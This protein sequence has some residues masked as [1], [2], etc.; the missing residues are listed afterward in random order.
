M[1]THYRDP[2]NLSY[3]QVLGKLVENISVLVDDFN[4]TYKNIYLFHFYGEGFEIK[5]SD[6]W[7]TIQTKIDSVQI[8]VNLQYLRYYKRHI[9]YGTTTPFTVFTKVPITKLVAAGYVYKTIQT[10][11]D[12]IDFSVDT[13]KIRKCET[14]S[15]HIRYEFQGMFGFKKTLDDSELEF[16]T[17]IRTAY[18][19]GFDLDGKEYYVDHR[20]SDFTNANVVAHIKLKNNIRNPY[21]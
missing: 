12:K 10:I 9:S 6:S 1:L 20:T 13:F 21:V 18:R 19:L 7:F 5:V 11:Y 8:N 3:F 15:P 16:L 14:L 2:T 4:S 17:I